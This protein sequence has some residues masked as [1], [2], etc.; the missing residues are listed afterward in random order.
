MNSLTYE[1]LGAMV[2][3]A[4]ERTAFVLAETVDPDEAERRFTPALCSVI[5]FTGAANG[6]VALAAD[7]PFVQE[8]ASSILGVEP[9]QVQPE[10]EGRDGLS[11][12]ANIVGGSIIIALGGVEN[13]YKYG[14]PRAADPA[15]LGAEPAG[16]VHTDI[17]S[18]CG[19]LRVSWLPNVSASQIAA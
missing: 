4:L 11:E 8:L 19:R 13:E 3:D 18:E 2:V 17:A 14:L 9:E 7:V 1:Q 16:A 12:L 10:K 6:C 5:D 15:Q